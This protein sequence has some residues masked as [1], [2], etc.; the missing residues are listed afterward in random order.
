MKGFSQPF[1]SDELKDIFAGF[2]PLETEAIPLSKGLSR[3]L[4]DNGM[5]A[6][7]YLPP[8]ARAA[9]DGFAVRA[10]DTFDCLESKPVQ[11]EIA[12]EIMMGSPGTAYRL[13][14][15]QT[16][17]IWTGGELPGESDGVVMV[18][19]TRMLD[20]SVVEIFRPVKV[21]ENIIRAGED[22]AP[23]TIIFSGNK[24]GKEKKMLRSQDL[25]VLAGLGK[26]EL[27]VH[28]RVKVGIISSGDEL[29][30]PTS[31]IEPGKTRDINS[32]ALN[33]LVLEAG[34]MPK[35]YGVIK[36]NPERLLT[37]CEQILEENDMLIISG[38]SSA[39][40]RDF[41]RQVFKK[42]KGCELLTHNPDIKKRKQT[43]LAIRGNQAV[44]GLPGHAVS[45]M[46]IFYLF[47]RPLIRKL[48]GLPTESGL[49]QTVAMTSQPIPSTVG[50]KE[51]VQVSISWHED[52]EL[53]V[54]TPVYGK[55]GL[56]RPLIQSDGLLV[57][58]K[59]VQGLAANVIARILLFP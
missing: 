6:G 51:F 57:I 49:T 20:N 58:D 41:T 27:R 42:I 12:G 55:S 47:I 44:C 4:A 14:P 34:A 56:L 18:E 15:G 30:L 33:A 23:E 9:M 46:I 24:A 11:L 8:F 53:P 16:V 31:P 1:S 2:S 7:E 35:C 26:T 54:A 39:G 10:K 28:K 40:K 38:G 25:G 45:T 36:D 50:K 17:K 59:D 3:V 48:S 5:A 22:F 29:I 52:R 43:L 21:W 19:Q 32:T 13:R 37:A